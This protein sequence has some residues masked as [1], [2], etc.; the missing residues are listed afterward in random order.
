MLERMLRPEG[1]AAFGQ[2]MSLP[3][4][5]TAVIARGLSCQPCWEAA[6]E[7]SRAGQEAPVSSN[8]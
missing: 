3:L 4:A 8:L 7:R 5:Q 1:C 2:G 6:D